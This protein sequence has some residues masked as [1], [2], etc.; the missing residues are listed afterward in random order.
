MLM[1]SIRLPHYNGI[2]RQP[3]DGPA[4]QLAV[5]NTHPQDSAQCF[6]DR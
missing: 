3:P 6:P 4:S 1:D 2:A 5:M